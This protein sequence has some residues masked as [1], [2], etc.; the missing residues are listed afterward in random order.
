MAE[1]RPVVITY[2]GAN[3]RVLLFAATDTDGVA[4]DL[5]GATVT[6]TANYEGATK[7][8]NRAATVTDAAGGLF[9]IT[10]TAAEI[11]V[12]GKY[13]AQVKLVEATL[14]DYL[15]P[16]IIEVRDPVIPAV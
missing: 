12:P 9:N 10:P 14:I 16:F 2:V 4:Y 3:G 8:N 13:N 1:Y 5:T 7:I 6:I 11:D 15:E